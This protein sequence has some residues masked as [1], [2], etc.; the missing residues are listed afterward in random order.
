MYLC[1]YVRRGGDIE[2]KLEL[3]CVS[4]SRFGSEHFARQ[5]LIGWFGFYI[6]NL[7]FTCP[8]LAIS[9][10]EAAQN[11]IADLHLMISCNSMVRILPELRI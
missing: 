8:M 4:A 1:F 5:L 9:Q 2:I 3:P 7:Q 10:T 6:A 11:L